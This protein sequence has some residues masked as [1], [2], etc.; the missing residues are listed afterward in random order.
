M[1]R[2][3]LDDK[4]ILNQQAICWQIKSSRQLYP[5]KFNFRSDRLDD[6]NVFTFLVLTCLETPTNAEAHGVS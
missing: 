1:E 2:V 6:L 5:E 4:D 3:A